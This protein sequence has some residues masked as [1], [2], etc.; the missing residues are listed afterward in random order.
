M[1]PWLRSEGKFLLSLDFTE[2]LLLTKYPPDMGTLIT[3][4][5]YPLCGFTHRLSLD[6]EVKAQRG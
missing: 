4:M 2:S 5:L 3:V 1:V 6:R